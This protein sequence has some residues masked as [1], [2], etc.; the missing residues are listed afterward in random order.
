MNT[1]MIA[2][3][4][5]VVLAVAL[6]VYGVGGGSEGHDTR[7]AEQSACETPKYW[8]NPRPGAECYQAPVICPDGDGNCNMAARL[9]T[10]TKPREGIESL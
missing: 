3:T 4:F 6:K 9:W 7:Q 5:C 8:T 1:R 10:N 2:L